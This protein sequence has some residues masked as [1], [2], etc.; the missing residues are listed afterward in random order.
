M[1]STITE[2]S[3]NVKSVSNKLYE[4]E[5][6]L[7][8]DFKKVNVAYSP[9]EKEAL[10][11]RALEVGHIE[12]RLFGWGEEG[13][14][15]WGYTHYE[16]GKK[17]ELDFEIEW[18]SFA[19]KADALA[20]VVE[21]KL[22]IP[23]ITLFEKIEAAQQFGEYW[24]EK[25]KDRNH[26]VCAAAAQ[27]NNG[28]LDVLGIVGVK[29]GASRST[30]NKFNRILDSKDDTLISQCRNGEISIS[31]AYDMVGK[32]TSESDSDDKQKEV[33]DDAVLAAEQARNCKRR[34][35]EANVLAKYTV[36]GFSN[37]EK[38]T[39]SGRKFFLLRWNE[40]HSDNCMTEEELE[41]A[42]KNY[43]KVK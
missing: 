23:T 37:G 3:V 6:K 26:P 42:V 40:E 8:D 9:E 15:L 34:M 38:L 11:I 14:L 13:I 7:D 19:T 24:Q 12:E 41:A 21:K 25:Y 17:N 10:S 20:F 30:V 36:E 39:K 35:K 32:D 4:I 18:V 33:S 27:K 2:N 29:A 43:E 5:V 22:S 1:N 31:A 28:V 16:I